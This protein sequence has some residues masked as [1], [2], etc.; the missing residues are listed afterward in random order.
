M[1]I[2]FPDNL[3]P[4]SYE[5]LESYFELFLRKAKRLAEAQQELKKLLE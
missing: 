1:T 4:T 5:D 2:T 3:S